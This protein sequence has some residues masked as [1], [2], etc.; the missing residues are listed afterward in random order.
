MKLSVT[1]YDSWETLEPIRQEW[2]ALVRQSQANEV[3]STYEFLRAWDSS[4]TRKTALKIVAAR[5][6]AG[7]A[8]VAPLMFSD[9]RKCGMSMTS[10]EFIGTP[11]SDYSDFIYHDIEA[12]DAMWK[13]VSKT[14][15]S[16]DILYLQQIKASSPTSAYLKSDPSLTARPCNVGLSA[17]L[18]ERANAPI[19]DYL[20]G[21]GLRKR[22]LRRIEKEG[23]VTLRV[24]TDAAG[25]KANLP[26][27]FEQ[28]IGRWR[29]TP[30]PSFFADQAV[31]TLYMNWAEHL[32][33]H[34][35][36]AVLTLNDTPV[37]TLF[38]FPYARK[39]IVHTVTYD[40]Q[41]RQFHCGLVC[42][43][44]VM[45]TLRDRGIEYVDF[46][47][48]TEGFKSFFADIPTRSDE[49]IRAHTLKGTCCTKLFFAARDLAANHEWAARIAAKFGIR[50][51]PG[52]QRPA[53]DA[54]G[55]TEP[56]GKVE[57]TRVA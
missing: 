21:P 51:N 41:Y 44:R 57:E 35:M 46:T 45:Q 10:L 27:L 23:V 16:A 4:N 37:A 54:Q 39:L 9:K 18:P 8:G 33:P 47:R 13:Y 42:I 12:L 25:I 1:E 34:V 11:N 31:K 20:K 5:D 56:E 50:A 2:D 30:T 3:F 36:L 26:T 55:G 52:D 17:R 53:I 19:Q 48:G 6:G 29:D 49:F 40:V 7:L 32:G 22:T 14:A 38:G 43:V 15:S 28:H 24:Y